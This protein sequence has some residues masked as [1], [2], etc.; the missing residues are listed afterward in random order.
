MSGVLDLILSP[1]IAISFVVFIVYLIHGYLATQPS[2]ASG[3]PW[4]GKGSSRFFSRTKASFLS[5]TRMQE[6]METG[7]QKVGTP[8]QYCDGTSV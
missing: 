3:V 7:Y 1:V 4:V 6:W 5:I 2:A 8:W